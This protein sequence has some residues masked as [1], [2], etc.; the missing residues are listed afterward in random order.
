MNESWQ[1]ISITKILL[2][3]VKPIPQILNNFRL[4]FQFQNLPK[5]I[6][7][8]CWNPQEVM[9]SWCHDMQYSIHSL[10]ICYWY[11]WTKHLSSWKINDK[12]W[13]SF[14]SRYNNS[15]HLQW[16]LYNKLWNMYH[17]TKEKIDKISKLWS[18]NKTCRLGK[19]SYDII[20]K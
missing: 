7:T 16:G 5:I 13:T 18:S 20:W 14:I 3:L 6:H 19:E 4:K 15:N 1:T 10:S 9:M 11:T 2:V 8:S 12:Q 17:L